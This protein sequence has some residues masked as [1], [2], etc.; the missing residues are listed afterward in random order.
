MALELTTDGT[1]D[2]ARSEARH[3]YGLFET[4]R[5]KEGQAQ[6][7]GL[8]LARLRQGAD[9]LGMDQPPALESLG[10]FLAQHTQVP[11]MASGVLRLYAVDSRLVVSAMAFS[12]QPRA[13]VALDLA[14][15]LTRNSSSPLNRFKTLAYLE[16]RVLAQEARDRELFEVIALNERGELTDG[17]RSTLF[18]V[19]G[20]RILTPHAAAGALP[21]V[22][23]QVILEAGLAQEATLTPSD[24]VR[25]QALFLTNSLQGLIPVH[26]CRGRALEQPRT[27]LEPVLALLG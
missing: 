5:V 13:L 19:E 17:S 18:L 4:L 3:G 12:P 26:S 25:C 27:I 16:N 11:T 22:A 1:V 21:G 15:S 8:H 20:G 10:A 14:A 7:L 6:R 2:L 23:R 9:F 24:L